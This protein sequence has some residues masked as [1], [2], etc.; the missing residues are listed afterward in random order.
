MILLNIYQTMKKVTSNKVGLSEKSCLGLSEKVASNNVR[1][2]EKRA[3][4]LCSILM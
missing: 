2:S 4:F 1:L 3:N